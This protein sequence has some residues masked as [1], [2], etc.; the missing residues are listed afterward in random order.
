MEIEY[1]V[2]STMLGRFPLRVTLFFQ[3]SLYLTV[4]WG[5]TEYGTQTS[6]HH[7]P[8][9]KNI[10]HYIDDASKHNEIGLI[11]YY[12]KQLLQKNDNNFQ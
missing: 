10:E 8:D 11:Y 7:N 3:P 12:T 2:D 5:A 1:V 4:Y 9:L 6:H